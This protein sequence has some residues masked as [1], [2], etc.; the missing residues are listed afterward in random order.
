[1]TCDRAF[2]VD[3]VQGQGLL[4]PNPLLLCALQNPSGRQGRPL[5]S[6]DPEQGLPR[7]RCYYCVQGLMAGLGWGSEAATEGIQ[8]RKTSRLQQELAL[9]Q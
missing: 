7:V 2:L 5:S 9:L 1:M 3:T 8:R 4:Q 6:D